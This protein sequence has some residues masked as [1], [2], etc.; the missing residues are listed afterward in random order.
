MFEEGLDQM[1]TFQATLD[2]KQQGTQSSLKPDQ[3]PFA[4][5]EAIERELDRLENAG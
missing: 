3:L 5:K 1:N 2:L 4:M